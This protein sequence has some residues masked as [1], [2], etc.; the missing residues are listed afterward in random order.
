VRAVLTVTPKH[1]CSDCLLGHSGSAPEF[2]RLLLQQIAAASHEIPTF[3]D[4][5]VTGTDIAFSATQVFIRLNGI[6][7]YVTTENHT[8]EVR[9]L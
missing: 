6:A 9:V 8:L 1:Q 7:N 5:I 4:I 3:T 2:R